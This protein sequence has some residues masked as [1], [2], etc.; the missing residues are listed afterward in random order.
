MLAR[1]Y[2]AQLPGLILSGNQGCWVVVTF[3]GVEAM[4]SECETIS[5]WAQKNLADRPYYI[6]QVSSREGVDGALR[7]AGV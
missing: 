6:G 2:R 7:A 5:A 1:V 4:A 3:E